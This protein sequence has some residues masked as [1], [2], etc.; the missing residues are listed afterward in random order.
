MP[1]EFVSRSHRPWGQALLPPRTEE[2]PEGRTLC[3]R[4]LSYVRLIIASTESDL[5]AVDDNPSENSGNLTNRV[6]AVGA[7]NAG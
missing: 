4:S 7:A 3:S 1:G 2:H 6:S 5:R